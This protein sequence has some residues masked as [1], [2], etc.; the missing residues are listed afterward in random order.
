MKKLQVTVPASSANLGPG[1][2]CLGLALDIVDTIDVDVLAEGDEVVLEH[3]FPEHVEL[4]R[5]LNLLCEG[6]RAWATDTGVRLPG[7]RFRLQSAI[8]IGKGLGSSAAALVAGLKTAAHVAGDKQ[9]GDRILRLATHIEGHADNVAASF[10]GGMTV[11]I[12]NGEEIRALP[13][14]NHLQLG[15]ALYIPDDELITSET[16]AAMPDRVSRSEAVFNVG[17]VAYL[18]AAI[19]WGAWEDVGLGMQDRLHQSFRAQ[20]IPA[21]RDVV[22]AACAAGAYGA[23][24]SGGGPGVIALCPRDRVEAVAKAME[25]QAHELNWAGTAMV[26]SVRRWGAQVKESS[27]DVEQ[28]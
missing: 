22:T 18:T 15:V 1:F 14:A 25:H 16:R 20:H 19:A 9:P 26:T 10:M 21:F 8:P 28:V 11:A 23:A 4:D 7:V 27:D 6:Y 3:V 5:T 2:D 13:I 17:R 24:L 12:R